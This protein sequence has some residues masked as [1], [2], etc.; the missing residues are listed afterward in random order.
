MNI[1]RIHKPGTDGEKFDSSTV[2]SLVDMGVIVFDY[3]ARLG[4]GINFHYYRK[5]D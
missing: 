3:V 2:R 4:N 1:Y 5:A